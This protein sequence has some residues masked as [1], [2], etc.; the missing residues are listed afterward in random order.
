MITFLIKSA[1]CLAGFWVFYKLFLEHE[2]I[3]RFNRIYLILGILFSLFIPFISFE[4]NT[5]LIQNQV[6]EQVLV[7]Q[8]IQKELVPKSVIQQTQAVDWTLV[9][10]M[11]WAIGSLILLLRFGAN[12]LA[13]RKKINQNASIQLKNATLVLVNEPVLPCTF[14][15]YV[16][17]NAKEYQS[18]AIEKEILN[19]EFCHVNQLH[20][21]D[22]IFIEILQ[23]VFWFNPIMIFYKTAI[24]LNH[25]FLADDAVNAKYRNVVNYQ[26]LL[27]QK[28]V[29]INFQLTSSST[30]QLTKQRLIMMTKHTPN[31]VAIVKFMAAFALFFVLGL[32]FSEVTI[33]QK[34][35]KSTDKPS[36][37]KKLS[38]T[39]DDVDY[40]NG[41]YMMWDKRAKRMNPK[42]YV[43]LTEEEKKLIQ[44]PLYH[45]RNGNPTEKMLASWSS[46]DKFGVWV[47]DKF[48]S[49]SKLK[50]Y[51]TT[52]FAYYGW[53]NLYGSARI[54][55]RKYQIDLM[56]NDYYENVYIKAE[57]KMPMFVIDK[58]KK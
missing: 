7:P 17:V 53:S 54:G 48:I 47:D 19:H 14:L 46:S 30:F 40:K 55:N 25:E 34:E 18:D 35:A 43:E 24:K 58:R 50:P 20:T 29:K 44:N 9:L 10:S 12:W 3:H 31:S 4:M 33:A 51:K 27:L 5:E 32:T 28:S 38:L 52:D 11:V 6:I 23:I 21:L 39:K 42:A 1:A 56:T 45:E 2:K 57:K 49:N 16:F 41:S 13:I 36:T 15:D 26:Q 37:P 22:V 8:F